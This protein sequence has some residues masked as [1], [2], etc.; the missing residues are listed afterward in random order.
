MKM[1]DKLDWRRHAGIRTAAIRIRRNGV[2]D[3]YQ[4]ISIV[5]QKPRTVRKKYSS[6]FHKFTS[7][8]YV[9]G[10]GRILYIQNREEGGESQ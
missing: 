6:V 10:S 2:R 8:L 4:T 1:N 7:F 3:R 9:L 5:K